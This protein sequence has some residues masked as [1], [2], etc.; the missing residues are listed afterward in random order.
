MAEAVGLE[1]GEQVAL[2]HA[3]VDRVEPRAQQGLGV[4]GTE[5]GT[6]SRRVRA[7]PSVITRSTIRSTAAGSGA[8]SSD[9][10]GPSARTASAIAACAHLA[11]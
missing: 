4:L 6:R 3:Q 5:V 7:S 11:A 8:A 1:E 10:R 2:A 9:R